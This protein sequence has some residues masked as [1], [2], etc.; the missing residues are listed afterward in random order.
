MLPIGTFP[1]VSEM[2]SIVLAGLAANVIKVTLLLGL[3]GVCALALRRGSSAT[4]HWM[5]SVALV[6]ALALPVL[7]AALPSIRL[8]IA[9]PPVQTPKLDVRPRAAKAPRVSDVTPVVPAPTLSTPQPARPARP[10]P[11]PFRAPPVSWPVLL[12]GVWIAGAV[13]LLLRLVLGQLKLVALAR[14]ARP[15]HAAAW[16]RLAERAAEQA[17]L[18]RPFELAESDEIG[19]PATFGV[20]R[21]T[22]LLPVAARE[23]PEERR[24]AVLVHELAHAARYDCLTQFLAQ[25]TCALYWFHPAVWWAEHRLRVEREQ[26]CDDRVIAGRM[27]ASDYADHLIQVLRETRA[28][29][30]PGFGAV[31]FARRSSLEGRLLALL[32]PLRD[33]EAPSARLAGISAAAIG[34]FSILLACAEIAPAQTGTPVPDEITIQG[35]IRSDG[36]AAALP[37]SEVRRAPEDEESLESRWA[38]ALGGSGGE[39]RRGGIWVGYKLATRVGGGHGLLSDSEGIDLA[40]LNGRAA[41]PTLFDVLKGRE[42]LLAPMD[43]ALLFHV[44]R[45][46]RVDR[47]RTQ[48]L[49]LYADLGGL[50][51]YWLGTAGDGQS[52]SWLEQLAGHVAGEEPRRALLDAVSFHAD[53]KA[54][55]WLRDVAESDASATLRAT[56]AEDLARHPSEESI[57]VLDRLARGDRSTEVRRSAIEALGD[58]DDGA[59]TTTLFDIARMKGELMDIR[60]EAVEALGETATQER[61]E[62]VEAL[63]QQADDAAAEAAG[64]SDEVAVE[65]AA[66]DEKATC[67]EKKAAEDPGQVEDAADAAD[68]SDAEDP[69][70]DEWQIQVQ[71]VETLGRMPE[72]QALP[73]L[74]KLARHHSCAQ[75]RREAAE[76]IAGFKSPQALDLLDD[77]AWKAP[78][79]QVQRQAVESFQ[80]FPSEDAI[81]HLARAARSHPLAVVR[82]QAVETLA[83]EDPEAALPVIDAVIEHDADETVRAQAVESLGQL[84]HEIGFPKLVHIAKSKLPARLRRQAIETLA[85][86]DPDAALPVLE[87]I[88]QGSQQTP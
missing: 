49:S 64:E 56:A 35:G 57:R 62:K 31:A 68:A 77:L 4:R 66:P 73:R 28:A 71:A 53:E 14:R 43:V 67:A 70:G 46:G 47:V 20:V 61:A 78:D 29:G 80:Q 21:P 24:V 22:V 72:E 2:L 45:D 34:A 55:G 33:R 60:R 1:S 16:T 37:P 76:T 81:P 88:L 44:T 23:W 38:W 84:P 79:P 63:Y 25:I 13:L 69:D 40:L 9:P 15:Q 41:G 19:V 85:Q 17:G 26:A 54:G 36:K 10:S 51:L 48:S 11:A 86:D 50:P 5:W 32:D 42:S 18:D 8:P 39:E 7:S 30:L 3:V 82:R 58:I 6:G 83:Q 27:R 12:L 74:E 65:P 87:E 52:L 75:V 59:A